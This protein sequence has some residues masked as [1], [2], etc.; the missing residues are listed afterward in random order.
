M[1]SLVNSALFVNWCWSCQS[2]LWMADLALSWYT[3]LYDHDVNFTHINNFRAIWWLQHTISWLRGFTSLIAW[4]I[5]ARVVVWLCLQSFTNYIIT[6]LQHWGRK[7]HDLQICDHICYNVVVNYKAS[8]NM[9]GQPSTCISFKQKQI[10]PVPQA[11][12]D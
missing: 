12:L 6:G 7:Q 10:E 5:E 9:A 1:F 3:V 11:G 8:V 2:G 4:R